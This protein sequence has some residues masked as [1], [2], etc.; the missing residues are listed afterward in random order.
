ME[1]FQISNWGD[2]QELKAF[3]ARTLH[4]G[5]LC[6]ARPEV[7]LVRVGLSL[8]LCLTWHWVVGCLLPG[9]CVVWWLFLCLDFCQVWLVP[10]LVLHWYPPFSTTTWIFAWISAAPWTG[11]IYFACL[12]AWAATA[13]TLR[14]LW[15]SL[16][17]GLLSVGTLPRL[18]ILCSLLVPSLV[19]VRGPLLTQLGPL[20]CFVS[21]LLRLPPPRVE[22]DLKPEN[23]YQLPLRLVLTVFCLGVTSCL[24]PILLDV[25]VPRVPGWLVCGLVL[26]WIVGSIPQTARP[27]W[28]CGRGFT[29]WLGLTLWIVLWCSAPRHPTGVPSAHLKAVLQCPS[30]SQVR[31]S[32][33]STSLLQVS[34]R[35]TSSSCPDRRIN[36]FGFDSRVLSDFCFSGHLPRR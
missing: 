17:F 25:I 7:E 22:L 8:L 15:I 29:L 11:Q 14:F 32:A 30:P 13:P 2:K 19:S 10:C 1:W 16:A 23:R 18:L 36:G 26:S 20:S 34:R 9:W 33:V 6:G 24:V 21:P 31:L 4:C 5:G 3:H 35:T 28:I 12:L 27:R